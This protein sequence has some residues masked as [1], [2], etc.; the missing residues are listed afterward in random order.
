VTFVDPANAMTFFQ[1]AS[2]QGLMLNSRRLKIGWGKHSGPLHP[3][4]AAAVQAGASRNVYVG[5]IL[6]FD[7]FD[8]ARLRKDFS[9]YG[10]IELINSLVEK[11]CSFVNFTSLANAMKALEGSS[12]PVFFFFLIPP[13]LSFPPLGL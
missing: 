12:L 5:G 1:L 6:D 7:A 10:E 3:T 13:L 9:E 4:T 11:K 8:E 2:T